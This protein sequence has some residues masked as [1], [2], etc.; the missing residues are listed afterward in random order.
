MINLPKTD[1]KLAE[2]KFIV[3]GRYGGFNDFDIPYVHKAIKEILY[4]R[5]DIFFLFANTAQFY[6]HPRIL[7]LDT[8]IDPKEKVKFIN[9]CDAM[10]HARVDGESFGLSVGEFSS[11]NKPIITT[12]GYY[13]NHIDI[14]GN[15]AIIYNS[16]ESLK[17]IFFNF[18]KIKNS[19]TD[20]NA[21]RDYTPEKV[22]EIFN[23]VYLKTDK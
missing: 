11:C 7:Y 17:E 1:E 4:E 15:F 6:I 10:I 16:K 22:M 12:Y 21:Y 8:I 23:Q 9:S 14:L 2:N 3:F 20:W 18:E 5:K 19:R 13:N